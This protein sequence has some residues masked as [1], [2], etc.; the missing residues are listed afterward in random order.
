MKKKYE[1]RIILIIDD[2]E[3]FRLLLR[4]ELEPLGLF[5]VDYTLGQEAI[6]EVI[7][8]LEYDIAFVDLVL[9]KDRLDGWY[10][11]DKLRK[12]HKDK[13]VIVMSS[14]RD[15]TGRVIDKYAFRKNPEPTLEKY[16]QR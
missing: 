8:G 15:P 10:V 14:E 11:Q 3:G 16:L 6:D 13:P 9:E 5:I 7:A 2:N 4:E 1:N 12:I